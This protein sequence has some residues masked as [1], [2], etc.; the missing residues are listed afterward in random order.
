[1]KQD[2]NEPSFTFIH[3]IMNEQNMHYTAISKAPTKHSNIPIKMPS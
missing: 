3:E 2:V 1:M